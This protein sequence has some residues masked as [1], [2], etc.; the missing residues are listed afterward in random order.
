MIGHILSHSPKGADGAWP[1]EE[2]REIVDEIGSTHIGRGIN[3]GRRNA[4][5]ATWRGRGGAQERALA[6]EYRAWAREIALDHPF[7][8][9]VLEKLAQSYDYEAASWDTDAEID[10]RL[11]I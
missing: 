9:N 5:G 10:D 11:R 7:T 3:M 6:A 1:C 4:R 2:V 8:A